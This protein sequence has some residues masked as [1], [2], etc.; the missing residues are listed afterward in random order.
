MNVRT[1][2]RVSV[3]PHILEATKPISV[4]FVTTIYSILALFMALQPTT[5]AFPTSSLLII[6]VTPFIGILKV[7][8]R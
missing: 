1:T 3:R 2:S 4:Q 6:S 7:K 8:R 5:L